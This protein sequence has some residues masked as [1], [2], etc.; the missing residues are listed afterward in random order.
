MALLAKPAQQG[1][2]FGDR[3]G[4]AGGNLSVGS[5]AD[6]CIFDESAEWVVTSKTLA[7]QGDNRSK[8]TG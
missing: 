4:V 5:C 7:S 2:E 8:Q 3:L 1:L 6:I